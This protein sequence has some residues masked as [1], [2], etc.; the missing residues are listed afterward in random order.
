MAPHSR[1]R[2]VGSAPGPR[3]GGSHT[4]LAPSWLPS[5]T[6]PSAAFEPCSGSFARLSAFARWRESKPLLQ[7]RSRAETGTISSRNHWKEQTGLAGARCNRLDLVFPVN[8]PQLPCYVLLWCHH[9]RVGRQQVPTL[10]LPPVWWEQLPTIALRPDCGR[11]NNSL[12]LPKSL[13]NAPQP[14]LTPSRLTCPA[15]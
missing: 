12:P 1:P 15:S 7:H 2:P 11:Q 3:S 6:P 8:C 4:G 10:S 14:H 13:E 9:S 5:P